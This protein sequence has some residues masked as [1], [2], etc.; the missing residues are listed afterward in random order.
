MMQISIYDTDTF[1]LVDTT[2]FDIVEKKEAKIARIKEE[3]N[4]LMQTKTYFQD[5]ID[6]H[7]KMVIEIADKIGDK[8][9]ELEKIAG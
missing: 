3:L 9:A 6:G 2:K 1:E 8:K 7:V 5:I 4:A